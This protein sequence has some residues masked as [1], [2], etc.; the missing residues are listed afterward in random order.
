MPRWMRSSVPSTWRP[1]TWP[2]S[3]RGDIP[4][5]LPL[6]CQ[7]DFRVLEANLN[8][9]RDGLEGL[10]EARSVLQAMAVNDYRV[11]MQGTYPGVFG[12]VKDA[13][14][15]VQDRVKNLTR[16]LKSI[17]RGDLDELG[18]VQAVGRCSEGDELLPSLVATM[19][20]VQALV[21][22]TTHLSE[23]AVAGQLGTRA[24]ASRHQGTL[25]P[26][27]GGRQCH[28]GRGASPHRGG[29]PRAGSPLRARPH[30]AHGR[31]PSRRPGAHR[32]VPQRGRGQPPRH[33][34]QRGHGGGAGGVGL[35]RDQLRKPEPG[36]GSLEAGRFAG[37]G[38]GGPGPDGLHDPPELRQCPRGQGVGR[39]CAHGL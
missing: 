17:A 36:R 31:E 1:T 6:T 16:I 25:P 11:A 5:R 12:D 8:A 28:A 29:L 35:D 18:E 34:G 22:D 27:G 33:P 9:C 26:G 4:P 37:R 19:A 32:P 30:G 14:Q 10:L 7:G 21:D 39:E 3:G 38:L 23:A 15:S 20:S 24:D 13:V 2:A